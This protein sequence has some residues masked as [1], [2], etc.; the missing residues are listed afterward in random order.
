MKHG[1]YID[2]FFERMDEAVEESGMSK[3]E[4]SR[5][6]KASPTCLSNMK[7]RRIM[8]SSGLLAKFCG[9]TGASADYL[10]GLKR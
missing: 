3:M 9:V 4:I 2:G 8:P 6:M 10:L 1:I 5:R 7:T